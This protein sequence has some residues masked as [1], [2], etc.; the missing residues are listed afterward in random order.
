MKENAKKKSKISKKVCLSLF[1]LLLVVFVFFIYLE[2]VVNP[3]IIDITEA[4]VDSLA[5][6]AVSDAIYYV[7]SEEDLDYSNLFQIKTD[8]QGDIVSILSNM[9]NLNILARQISTYSQIYLDKLR[10]AKVFVSLGAFSGMPVFNEMGPKVK[11]QLMPIGSVITSFD[12]EFLSA[13]INQTKHS[14]YVD[15]NSI[16]TIIL[17]TCSK[18]I[19]FVTQVLLC[20]NIIVGKIPDIYFEN[21]SVVHN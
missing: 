16:I 3:M 15:V 12:S 2:L 17:P 9:E 8:S 7:I 6:T 18:K 20:E 4:E 13:G 1:S 19:E 14:M 5:T 11:I 21:G 10:N